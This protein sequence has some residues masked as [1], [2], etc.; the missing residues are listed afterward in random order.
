M[1]RYGKGNKQLS[2]Q[3]FIQ[4][5]GTIGSEQKKYFDKDGKAREGYSLVQSQ[6]NSKPVYTHTGFGMSK[7][8]AVYKTDTPVSAPP[9]PA[10]APAPA[11]PAPLMPTISDASKKYRAETDAKLATIDKKMADFNASEAAAAKA[12]ELANEANVRNF[13]IQSANQ[14]RSSQTPNLQIQ[15]ASSTP[16]TAGTG[17]FRI[18]KRRG[19]NQQQLASSLNIGQSNTLNI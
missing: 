12:A 15:P 18:R 9:A 7:P 6:Q 3:E 11:A 13:A 2:A 19:A 14:S 4:R 5:F 8:Q 17:A 16:Q 10:P 1:A